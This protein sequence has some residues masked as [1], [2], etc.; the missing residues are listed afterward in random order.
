MWAKNAGATPTSVMAGKV[1]A[2]STQFTQ[3]QN[4]TVLF[5]SLQPVGTVSPSVA[6]EVVPYEK[7]INASNL[8]CFILQLVSNVFLSEKF[9]PV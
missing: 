8:F 4:Q 6:H 1:W 9:P 5:Y 7:K 2:G 3:P